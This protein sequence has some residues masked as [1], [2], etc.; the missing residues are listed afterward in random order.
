VLAD[1]A[2]GS[3]NFASPDATSRRGRQQS[4]P[5]PRSRFTPA[6]RDGACCERARSAPTPPRG[7]GP[8]RDRVPR[9][10]SSSTGRSPGSPCT[11]A[12][13]C[14]PRVPAPSP[15]TRPQRVLRWSPSSAW[16]SC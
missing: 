12:L 6:D 7:E 3:G 11:R 5:L 2:S 4:G 13:S 10:F 14:G 16:S 15:A 8:L 9:A 1:V